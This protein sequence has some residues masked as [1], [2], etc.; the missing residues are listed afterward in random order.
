[1]KV[2]LKIISTANSS[3]LSIMGVDQF[4][5]ESK[6]RVVGAI[7]VVVE[8][9]TTY[10]PLHKVGSGHRRG[11]PTISIVIVITTVIAIIGVKV[12]DLGEGVNLSE[13]KEERRR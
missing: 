4:G 13:L 8:G 6:K 12:V 2:Y 7:V 3:K 9:I 1:M 10:T 11:R 5:K